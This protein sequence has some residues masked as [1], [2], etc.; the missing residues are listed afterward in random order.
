[1][2]EAQLKD[3]KEKIE[4]AARHLFATNG[5]DGTSIRDI[6][7]TAEVNIAAINY[8]FSSK[9]MLFEALIEKMFHEVSFEI[10]AFHQQNPHLSVED[11]SLWI[12]ELFIL[13]KDHMRMFFKFIL[14]HKS[15]I[16]P[17]S[18]DEESFGPPGGM[19]FAQ[20][21]ANQL[22]RIPKEEDIFWAVKTIF[23]NIVHVALMY[24]NHISKLPPEDHPFHQL[25]ILKNDLKRL[26]TVVLR[27][28]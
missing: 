11:F 16:S 27:D 26:V 14:D 21:I 15:N 2:T 28:I 13:R 20:A 24:A 25:P 8:H 3:T 5:F 10:E 9:E 18:K 1:M 17:C 7:K 22:G 6:S 23:S 19:V 12:F 4:Q